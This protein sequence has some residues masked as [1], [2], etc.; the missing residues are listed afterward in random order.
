MK[1][2]IIILSAFVCLLASCKDVKNYDGYSVLRLTP[3]TFRQ[4]KLL[5][6]LTESGLNV[7]FKTY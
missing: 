5:R 1:S 6:K 2:S 3:S 7:S 4:H